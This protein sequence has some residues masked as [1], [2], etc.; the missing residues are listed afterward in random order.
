VA[1]ASKK[2]L[3]ELPSPERMDQIISGLKSHGP[4]ATAILGA[5][6]LEH[7][8]ELLIRS[9]FKQLSKE[10]DRRMYNGAA[11]GILGSFSAKIR[12][13]YAANMIH[14]RPYNALLLINNVRNVFAHSLHNVGFDQELIQED[15]RKLA[16]ISPALSDAAGIL[17]DDTK[18]PIDV[19]ARIVATLYR[20]IRSKIED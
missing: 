2:L 9:H 20:A 7:A 15:C 4:Q 17:E 12:L 1:S 8:I 11:G 6:Y 5:A 16:A 3:K 10:D 18:E 13:A 19:F 14:E